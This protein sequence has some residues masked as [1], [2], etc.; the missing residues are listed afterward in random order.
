MAVGDIDG[1]GFMD[2]ATNGY[3]VKSPGSDFTKEWKV[4]SI[5]K[6]WYN[7]EGDWSKN[8]TKIFCADIDKDGKA[9][10]FISHSERAGYPVAWY[11]LI[12]VDKNTWEEHV[13]DTIAACHTLQVYDFDGDGDV[14]VLAGE[15]QMRWDD[16]HDPVCLYLNQGDNMNF[17]K[18]LLTTR[19]IYNGLAGDIDKDGDVDFMRL[20]GHSHGQLEM[21]INQVK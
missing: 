20:P 18:Q 10:V 19:G 11:D 9:E 8:A 2:I 14:D 16:E 4:Q 1:D 13:I 15:N 6:K 17:T 3:W 12:D 5:D 7:Q 21:W